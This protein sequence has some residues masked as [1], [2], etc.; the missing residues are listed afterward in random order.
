VKQSV[1]IGRH[2]MAQLQAKAH[3]ENDLLTW[4]IYERPADFPDSYVVR[5]H[6][7]RVAC[8][9]S[10]HFERRNLESVRAALEGLGLTR[11]ERAP[12]DDPCILETWI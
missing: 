5:P 12:S 4:T 6:S 8:P 2:G 7:S 9:L 11:L 3:A 10:V 1:R